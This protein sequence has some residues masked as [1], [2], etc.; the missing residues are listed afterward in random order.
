MEKTYKEKV[1]ELMKNLGVVGVV[2]SIN[3]STDLGVGCVI[4]TESDEVV[5]EL[6]GFT[7]CA[8]KAFVKAMVNGYVWV[9]TDTENEYSI[10]KVAVAGIDFLDPDNVKLLDQYNEPVAVS[11]EYGVKWALT[12]EF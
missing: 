3:N 5:K 6:E 11:K 12:K 4:D 7:G 10:K 8:A 2:A 9:K 1:A